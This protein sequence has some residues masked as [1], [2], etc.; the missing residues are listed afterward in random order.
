MYVQVCVWYLDAHRLGVSALGGG[1]CYS[2]KVRRVSYQ[3]L[4]G[5]WWVSEVKA[6]SGPSVHPCVS[7]AELPIF[8]CNRRYSSKI[9]T[10]SLLPGKT[11]HLS[12]TLKFS[13]LM[14]KKKKKKNPQKKNKTWF[15][16]PIHPQSKG[17]TLT[18]LRLTKQTLLPAVSLRPPFENHC[19]KRK[20]N[21]TA[22][23]W[24]KGTSLSWLPV[25]FCQHIHCVHC[26]PAVQ[27]T[28][29]PF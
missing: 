20:P 22:V 14:Q 29:N 19:P 9:V 10:I 25:Q 4:K 28:S 21:S 24:Q 3:N 12:S 26:V 6:I 17:H 13:W 5:Q 1:E 18:F 23:L 2:N 15:T 16:Y 11:I 27:N 8:R 7:Q